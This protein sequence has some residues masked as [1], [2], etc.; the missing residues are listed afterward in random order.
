MIPVVLAI[1]GMGTAWAFRFEMHY[2]L[3]RVAIDGAA[4]RYGVPPRLIAAVIWQETRFN[5][6]CRG[7]AGEI[8]LMQVMPLS[9]GEWAK[10]E[11]L[12][13]FEPRTLF[14]PQTNILAGTWYLGRALRRWSAQ[15]D[16]IPYA[17]AEYNAG[18]S[19][20]LRWERITAQAP[21]SFT[22]M[23]GYP[24]TRSYVRTIL[25]HY[26]SFGKP[27]ERW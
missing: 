2:Y 15:A 9:A 18:R 13:G 23:I 3:N 24:G 12:E 1:L 25:K 4:T 16:P 26:H 17:L 11:H 8:G 19:N 10:A 20:A 7:K 21:E 14:N 22:D 27:W 6:S 5:T